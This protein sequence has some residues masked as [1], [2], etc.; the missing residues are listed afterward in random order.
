MN[1][2]TS[3]IIITYISD[4]LPILSYFGSKIEDN[5]DNLTFKCRQMKDIQINRIG[6]SLEMEDCHSLLICD[7]NINT[8]YDNFITK[9]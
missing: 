3:A 4:H 2:I 9:L 7:V 6:Q 1:N 8:G 5:P